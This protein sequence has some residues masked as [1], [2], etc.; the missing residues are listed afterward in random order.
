VPDPLVWG[1]NALLPAGGALYVASLRGAFRF[2]GRRLE[3]IEGPGAAFSLAST[4]EGVAIGYAQGV[5]LPG[6]RLV[7]AF[8]GLPG[9]QAL[10]LSAGDEL[11]VGMPSGLGALAGGR[12]RW[13]VTA[14]EGRLPHP[15]VTALARHG[16]SLYAATYGGGV[17]RRD[18]SAGAAYEP[19]PETAGFRVNPG[20][21]V[22]AHGRLYL[23]TDGRGLHQLSGREF[24]PLR[25]PLPSPRVTA[26]WAEADALWVGTDEG[27]SRVD[28]R[29]LDAARGAGP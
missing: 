23:G 22:A 20:C 17:V 27:L 15:W 21:L 26:L 6:P 7:S 2:D 18:A 28:L 9:N 3:A 25:L 13:R 1:V 14:G 4:R 24:R 29:R 12:V 16:A 8:H 10:A 5:A 19:F 11:V